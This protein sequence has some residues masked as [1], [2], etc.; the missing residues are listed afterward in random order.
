M[1]KRAM[2][3]GRWQPCHLAHEWLI[4][5]KLDEGIPCL[6]L[7]RNIEPDERNPYT[8][9]ETIELLTAAFEGEDVVILALPCDIM[10]VY[11]GRDV[12]YEFE[13]LGECPERGISGTKIREILASAEP[14]LADLFVSPRVATKLKEIHGR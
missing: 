7:V 12:G 9:Q 5:Q 1:T 3:V 6:V 4:R 14:G 13:C 11:C 10:G 8:T 2:F